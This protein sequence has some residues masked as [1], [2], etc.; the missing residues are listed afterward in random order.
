M[1]NRDIIAARMEGHA[2]TYDEQARTNANLFGLSKR[3][4]YDERAKSY[5]AKAAALRRQAA[6]QRSA[7]DT[8]P[9]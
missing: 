7:P 4:E 9:N 2:I 8:I 3:P 6:A 5:A 1:N